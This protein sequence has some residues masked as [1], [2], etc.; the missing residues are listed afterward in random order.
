VLRQYRRLLREEHL[1]YGELWTDTGLVA[2]HEDG[3]AINPRLFS[4]WFISTPEPPTCR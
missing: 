4:A 2:T 3:T 1:R